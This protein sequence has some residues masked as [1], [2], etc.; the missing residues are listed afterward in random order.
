VLGLSFGGLNSACFGLLASES[1]Y[2]IAMQSPALHPVPQIHVAWQ[3]APVADLQIFFSTVTI[4][5]SLASTRRFGRILEERAA[6]SSTWRS[7]KATIGAIGSRFSTT[8]R[9]FSSAPGPTSS[10]QRPGADG[11]Q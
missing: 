11:L 7:S 8:W 1:F 10:A 3:E 9:S 2:G 5:D 6:I 4:G